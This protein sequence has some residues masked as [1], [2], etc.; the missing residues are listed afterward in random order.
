MIKM[1][2]LRQTGTGLYK[3]GQ[4]PFWE[5]G[6]AYATEKQPQRVLENA[7]KLAHFIAPEAQKKAVS[8]FIAP[9]N[10]VKLGE[11]QSKKDKVYQSPADAIYNKSV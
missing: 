3:T 2:K 7:E 5:K 10:W 4:H 11:N 1:I 9:T 8:P 6:G